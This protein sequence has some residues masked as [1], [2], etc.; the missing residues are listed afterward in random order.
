[1]SRQTEHLAA[2]PEFWKEGRHAVT[3]DM[4]REMPH[5][6]AFNV[7]PHIDVFYENGYTREEM[8]MVHETRKIMGEE[9]IRVHATAVRVP[10]FYAHAEAISIET[11]KAIT[12]DEARTILTDAP[13]IA[14][15]DNP[16]EARYPL[17]IHA[18]GRDEVF[19]GRIRT[20]ESVK[21][22]L[23]LWVVSDNLRKGAALNAIQIAEHLYGIAEPSGRSA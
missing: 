8:K 5:Q 20:D 19:V 23:S 11:E 1:M 7:I 14:V 10:V 12:P 16:S 9:T 21:H 6:I 17:P 13:G 3:D 4:V 18:E 22:G 15:V 2:L